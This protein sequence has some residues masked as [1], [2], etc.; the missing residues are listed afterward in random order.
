MCNDNVNQQRKRR[1]RLDV[2]L[3]HHSQS[4]VSSCVS[5]PPEHAAIMC[6]VRYGVFSQRA[7]HICITVTICRLISTL[8][9]GSMHS[10]SSLVGLFVVKYLVKIAHLEYALLCIIPF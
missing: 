4:T 3:L 9:S 10:Y 1:E 8:Y 5:Q 6:A 2:W 7:G